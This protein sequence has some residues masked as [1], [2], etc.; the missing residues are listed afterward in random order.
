[1]SIYLCEAEFAERFGVSRRTLQRHRITGN[2]PP[3]TRVGPRRIIY[4]LAAAEAWAAARTYPHL[5]SE[6]SRHI[7]GTPVWIDG[8]ESLLVG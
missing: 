2:G 5:A 3:F 7:T 8:A 6:R 1:M 4:S